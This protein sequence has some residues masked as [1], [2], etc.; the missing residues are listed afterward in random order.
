M[1]YLI[2]CRRF[3]SATTYPTSMTIKKRKLS[4]KG[5]ERLRGDIDKFGAYIERPC[6]KNK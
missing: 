4:L 6:L 3:V 1:I 2:F 5:D